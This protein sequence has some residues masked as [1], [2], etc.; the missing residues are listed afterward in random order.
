MTD[1]P[2]KTFPL[3]FTVAE[4]SLMARHLEVVKLLGPEFEAVSVKMRFRVADDAIK[5][6]QRVVINGKAS[7]R[8]EH[9]SEQVMA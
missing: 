8:S 6:A 7:D 4:I 5:R 3:W 1:N 2:K 9:V